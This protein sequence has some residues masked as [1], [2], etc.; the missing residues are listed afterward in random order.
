MVDLAERPCHRHAVAGAQ[1]VHAQQSRRVVARQVLDDFASQHLGA[2]PADR[3]RGVGR[4]VVAEGARQHRH[5]RFR[6]R[7]VIRHHADRMK[8]QRV[9]E[10][11]R[12]AVRIGQE[13][14]EH[15]AVEPLQFLADV[16]GRRALLERGVQHEIVVSRVPRHSQW[17]GRQHDQADR[18]SGK[19]LNL[20]GMGEGVCR[21]A[22]FQQRRP[23]AQVPFDQIEVLAALVV[24]LRDPAV[25]PGEPCGDFAAG[26]DG[27]FPVR[28]GAGQRN[29]PGCGGALPRT[30]HRDRPA[31]DP[32]IT[33]RP[34][35]SFNL[36]DQGGAKH[37]K[38][39]APP[40]LDRRAQRDVTPG[41]AAGRQRRTR[42]DLG[43]GVAT[44]QAGQPLAERS[45]H[46]ADAAMLRLKRVA[47]ADDELLA[48]LRFD[49]L[50]SFADH[51]HDHLGRLHRVVG[52][53][54]K[55]VTA[56]PVLF[57]ALSAGVR[58]VLNGEF[59]VQAG[60]DH[61]P[62]V[63]RAAFE[64]AGI[65]LPADFEGGAL[66]VLVRAQ[67]Q[68]RRTFRVVIVRQ[69]RPTVDLAAAVAPRHQFDRLDGLRRPFRAQ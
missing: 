23:C 39:P 50:R 19:R 2:L 46:F 16:A 56:E 40:L 24:Y 15:R 35:V 6:L 26:G 41:T 5:G 20:D 8:A 12:A 32:A 54:C 47:E 11:E 55:V 9:G 3:G 67:D 53:G 58:N 1:G 37:P 17:M 34:P 59:L 45:L 60:P 27:P 18:A 66:P 29:E 33:V 14:R 62:I 49:P 65:G 63:D 52:Q 48:L 25:S 57:A 28:P 30:P 43:R 51:R 13:R 68:H 38:A 42:C 64:V 61:H 36:G 4:G 69:S 44:A 22:A 7:V 10:H 31:P 21:I